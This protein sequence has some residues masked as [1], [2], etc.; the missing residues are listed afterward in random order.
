M[1]VKTVSIGIQNL[2]VACE[3]AC[4]YCLLRSNKTEE[5]V[6]YFRGRQLA[7]RFVQWA[8]S[9]DIT[10]LPYYF[11]GYCAEYPELGDNIAFNRSAGFSGADFLQCNG[12]KIRNQK[13]TDEL[14]ESLKAA[15]ITMMDM[16]F[17]G[18]KSYHDRFAAREGAFDFM[19]RLA[20]SAAEQGSVCAPTLVITEENRNV[21]DGVVEVLTSITQVESIHSFLPDYRGRGDLLEEVRLT[22]EGY[23]QLSHRVKGT[24]NM[25]RY[26]T[27][28]EWLSMETLP[29]YTQRALTITLR[30]DNIEQLEKMSCEEIVS[31]VEELD[32][33][34]YRA[35][36]PVNDLA[37]QYGDPENR[38]LYRLRDLFW[39]WQRRY[40]QEHH[41]KLYDVTDERLC[42]SVRS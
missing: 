3:C 9:K 18:D 24:L 37:R 2:C 1:Q 7:Q 25:K 26:R 12:I 16:T 38:R 10:P 36:P 5:G 34:Y 17:Y 41:L 19:L 14:V 31:H 23:E 13:E 42:C 32:D 6:D 8:K 40:I 28:G 27:E 21:L 35:I 11:I 20:K 4:R 15:G 29:E 33:A 39:K 22:E 30:K